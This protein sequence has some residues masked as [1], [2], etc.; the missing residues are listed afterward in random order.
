MD[1]LLHFHQ[2]PRPL[3]RHK[4]VQLATKLFPRS[5]RRLVQFNSGARA[6][7]D[8]QDAEARN[9]FITGYFEP[10]FFEIAV[11]IM[12]KGGGAFFDGGA[13]FGLCSFGLLSRVDVE[14]A[15]HH[16]FEANP[17]LEAFLRE[18]QRAI[19]PNG[20]MFINIGCLSDHEGQS[21][22][23]VN[24]MDT[25]KS[26]LNDSGGLIV[27]NIVLDDYLRRAALHKIRLLKLDIEGRS[28]RHFMGLKRHWFPA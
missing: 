15:D 6:F 18:S 19:A 11:T 7:L 4:V 26:H 2:L 9:V 1:P 10:E 23:E 17:N 8:L 22:F 16:L 13:N 20:Q 14:R 28:W 25:G 3:R 12:A 27:P 21:R 24:E 5:G